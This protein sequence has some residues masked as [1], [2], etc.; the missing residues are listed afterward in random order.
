MCGNKFNNPRALKSRHLQFRRILLRLEEPGRSNFLPRRLCYQN[1]KQMLNSRTVKALNQPD[2]EPS[3]SLLR[4]EHL[5]W[6]AFP[7]FSLSSLLIL[8]LRTRALTA[9][10]LTFLTLRNNL[11]DCL[12]RGGN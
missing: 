9:A 8:T 10:I 1:L 6:L 3:R 11:T 4:N 5:D 2:Q 12:L 7:H